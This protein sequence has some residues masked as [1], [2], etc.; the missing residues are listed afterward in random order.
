MHEAWEKGVLGLKNAFGFA[1]DNSKS[2]KLM[3]VAV[4]MNVISN[5]L[6]KTVFQPCYLPDSKESASVQEILRKYFGN[7][8]RTRSFMHALFLATHS[9][10]ERKT[11][12]R[13]WASTAS[14]SVVRKL[15]FMCQDGG[16]SLASRTKDIFQSAADL[17][18]EIQYVDGD[19][20]VVMFDNDHP[21]EWNWGFWEDF[22]DTSLQSEERLI[23][24]PG[25]YDDASKKEL[26]HGIALWKDQEHV[27][28]ANSEWRSFQ[29]ARKP[30]LGNG[31]SK[32]PPER[33]Q[34]ISFNGGL[35]PPLSPTSSPK[36]LQPRMYFGT[37][38][39]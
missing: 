35:T 1:P 25:F 39:K 31:L 38:A 10:D 29:R 22:G 37:R 5:E 8:T 14:R 18:G 32:I 26:H 17:W 12:L 34:S 7:D 16:T 2:A 36:E 4:A 15:S 24:F 28:S 13:G 6:T 21:S 9:A 23:L 19:I 20:K 3:R 33:R 27:V 30:K 11:V